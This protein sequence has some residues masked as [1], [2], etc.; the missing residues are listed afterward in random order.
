VRE[1]EQK[2]AGREV[3]R[4]PYW[5]GFAL[6]PER[7]EFWWQREFRLHDRFEYRFE[8]SAW[9]KRRLNP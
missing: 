6:A 9:L 4:P 5:T 2:Y 7:V 3:P 1:F 8:G